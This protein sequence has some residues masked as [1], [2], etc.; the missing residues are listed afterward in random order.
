MKSVISTTT[1]TLPPMPLNTKIT[2]FFPTV[3]I[4]SFPTDILFESYGTLEYTNGLHLETTLAI[5][6]RAYQQL[7]S[8]P[9]QYNTVCKP[10]TCSLVFALTS[11][12]QTP[13]WVH[14]SQ[15]GQYL[16]YYFT[17]DRARWVRYSKEYSKPLLSSFS[18]DIRQGPQGNWQRDPSE[19]KMFLC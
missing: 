9:C 12:V 19:S 13:Q 16:W 11:R 1:P 8:L 2:T 4:T 15:K 6:Y 14:T 3:V 17:I 7:W 18:D 5:L 10:S